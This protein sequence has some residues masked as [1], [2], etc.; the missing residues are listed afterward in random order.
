MGTQ[1]ACL[2]YLTQRDRG[3]VVCARGRSELLQD[4]AATVLVELLTAALRLLY[5]VG[6][7]FMLPGAGSADSSGRL[8]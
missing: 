7:G 1:V 4:C 5:G 8:R 6:I 2:G 3:T